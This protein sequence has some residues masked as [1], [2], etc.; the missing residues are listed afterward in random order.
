MKNGCCFLIVLAAVFFITSCKTAKVMIVDLTVPPV[1]EVS[2]KIQSLTLV[3]RAVDRRF[4]DD[5][6]D[7][8]QL[9]F[10]ESQFNLDTVIYD[11][12]AS[13]TLLKAL[14]NLL[15]E[16]GRFDVVIP[17]NRFLERDTVNLYADQMDWKE[18]EELTTRFN[19]DAVLSLDYFKTGISAVFGKIPNHN[20]QVW[21]KDFL[22]LAD[23]RVGYAANFRMYY[24]GEKENLISYFL[25]DTLQWQEE[26]IEITPLF[27]SFT[28]V[29]DA[30][31]EAGIAA[32][33]NLNNR[34]APVWKSYERAWFPSGSSLLRETAA[35]VGNN[36]WEA[37]M[38]KWKDA[39]DSK[40]SKSL[41]SILEFNTALAYEMMGDLDEAIRWGLKSYSS[42]YRPVTQNYL[43]ILKERKRLFEK[44]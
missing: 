13:D 1:E 12:S 14:G 40:M 34:I 42:F 6:K 22:Y 2:D 44:K 16:S 15:Y 30:L 38:K 27:K 8:I 18:V 36:E 11:R 23:M 29:K 19:T 20:W 39:A 21:D 3:N 5:P 7:T 37:A 9:R 17:E 4:T 35:M 24:P 25:S 26:H 32:A 31:A 41:R 10:Y 43:N 33:L 28:K